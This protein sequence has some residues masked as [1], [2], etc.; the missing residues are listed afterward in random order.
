MSLAQN[1][2][3]K[4][5]TWILLEKLYILMMTLHLFSSYYTFPL[6]VLYF[7]LTPSSLD[8][9]YFFP[10]P[11]SCYPQTNL[12][13]VWPNSDWPTVTL[14]AS[15]LCTDLNTGTTPYADIISTYKEHMKE[16][17]IMLVHP[18][19]TSMWL[20]KFEW[21]CR[22]AELALLNINILFR[23]KHMQGEIQED[24]IIARSPALTLC[25]LGHTFL[26]LLSM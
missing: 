21:M 24:T 22:T 20:C 1:R 3:T 18:G 11:P 15:W 4:F 19:S 10:S 25:I 7:C 16:K 8:S 9:I 6:H 14:W 2:E 23:G 12:E 17:G 13:K 5:K 26:F